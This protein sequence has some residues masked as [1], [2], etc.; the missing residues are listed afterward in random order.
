MES[1]V[2]YLGHGSDE[3]GREHRQHQARHQLQHEPI[4]PQ[5]ELEEWLLVAV[6]KEEMEN[7]IPLS[8]NLHTWR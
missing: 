4:Q 6:L 5:V 1:V 3:A 8:S 7:F 2:L